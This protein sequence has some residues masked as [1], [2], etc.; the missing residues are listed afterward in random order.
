LY[1][2]F[3]KPYFTMARRAY[4]EQVGEN[5]HAFGRSGEIH[6]L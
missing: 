2:P 4:S 1:E 5:R 6:L 3:Q